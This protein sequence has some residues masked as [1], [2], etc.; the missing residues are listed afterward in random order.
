MDSS[1]LRVY[2]GV[3]GDERRA[4]RRAQLIEAGLE[5]LGT[6]E[7]EPNL[8]VRGVCKQ[9]GL[10]SRYFYESFADRDALAVAVFDHV[11]SE[12]TTETLEAVKSAP[13]DTRAKLRAGLGTIVRIIAEDPR[14]GRLLFSPRLTSTLLVQRRAESTRMFARLLGGQAQEFYGLS[15]E[16]ELALVSE[17]LV[18]GLAQTL[19]SWLDGSLELNENSMIEQCVELFLTLGEPHATG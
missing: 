18:G 12:I 13:P 7:R 3:P 14:H 19:T 1:S 5:L 10:A 11:T 9:A 16:G 17:F 6:A 2:G 15:D 8:T 4:D